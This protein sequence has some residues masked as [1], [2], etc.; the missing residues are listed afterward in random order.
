VHE[1]VREPSD[2]R[3]VQI[4]QEYL[5]FAGKA[6]LYDGLLR[7]YTNP[8]AR[9]YF[10]A[11]M[12]RDAP[13][14]RLQPLL[15][16]LP[17]DSLTQRKAYLLNKI[18]RFVEPLFPNPD[19]W[20]WPAISEVMLARLEGSRRALKGTLFEEIVRRNLRT[21]FEGQGMTLEISEGE[22]RVH[23]ETYDVKVSGPKGSILLPVKTRE[24]M[25]GGHALLFTRDIHKSISVA[26]DHG[27]RCVPIVIAESWGGDLASL[28]SEKHIYIQANPNQIAVIEPDLAA[29]LAALLPE[30]RALL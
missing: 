11:W 28:P 19:S 18:R 29:K 20:D 8:Q 22:I 27:F 12:L 14:Q 23:D 9:W 21:L 3:A 26:E 2:E 13:A 24:T 5:G 17:G 7:P 15:A 10:L 25:G 16:D 6:K 30:F 1:F 4:I